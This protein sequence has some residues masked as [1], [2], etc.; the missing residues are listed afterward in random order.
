MENEQKCN[1]VPMS[2]TLERIPRSTSDVIVELAI[3]RREISDRLDKLQKAINANP[4]TVSDNHK[5][6][7][8]KQADAMQM[9]K[10]VLSERIKD[11]IDNG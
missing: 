8:R 7:W 9:Y 11:L 1:E 4:P 10:D 3:E 2:K 6:L 5:E